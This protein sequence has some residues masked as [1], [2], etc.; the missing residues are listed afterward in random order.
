MT[1]RRFLEIQADEFGIVHKDKC[2]GCAYRRIAAEVAA[3]MLI[4]RL[5]KNAI[6][7]WADE[8]QRRWKKTKYYKLWH[9]TK[10]ARRSPARAFKARGWEL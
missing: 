4:C 9:A 7:V 3:N 10:K 1:A 6:K 8:S 2:G 5:P